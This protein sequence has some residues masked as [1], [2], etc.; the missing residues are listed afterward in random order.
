MGSD[1]RG[2][3][4]PQAPPWRPQ[5]LVGQQ[6]PHAKESTAVAKQAI[7]HGTKSGHPAM[8]RN[9]RLTPAPP[10]AGLRAILPTNASMPLAPP[11]TAAPPAW[12][13]TTPAT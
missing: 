6:P 9:A 8:S 5:G 10:P 3:V 4:D 13:D 7:T 1:G 2:A 12:Q 11:D